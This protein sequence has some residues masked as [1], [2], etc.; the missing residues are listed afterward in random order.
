MFRTTDTNL[1]HTLPYEQNPKLHLYLV[2]AK[3]KLACHADAHMTIRA[4]LSRRCTDSLSQ[5]Q[6]LRALQYPGIILLYRRCPPGYLQ[7]A[8]LWVKFLLFS[9][10]MDN[11]YHLTKHGPRAPQ[12]HMFRY[13]TP[14]PKVFNAETSPQSGV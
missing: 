4:S 10:G 8:D 5:S 1:P 13:W 9:F 11:R 7:A 12:P 6:S 14:F 2:S 3:Y